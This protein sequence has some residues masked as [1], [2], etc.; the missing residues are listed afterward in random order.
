M[1]PCRAAFAKRIASLP[2]SDSFSIKLRAEDD[3]GG[4]PGNYQRA[5]S[6]AAGHE[7]QE[8]AHP[9][10]SEGETKTG[11]V[12]DPTEVFLCDDLESRRP[13]RGSVLLKRGQ[14][15]LIPA[16]I[17]TSQ[18]ASKYRET[19]VHID[20]NAHPSRSQQTVDVFSAVQF[21]PEAVAIPKGVDTYN[22]VEGADW[23][24]A[25]ADSAARSCT[26]CSLRATWKLSFRARFGGRKALASSPAA[27]T[28]RGEKSVPTRIR[29]GLS[30]P[31]K[32][33]R[34]V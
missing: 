23:I 5:H 30:F 24:V 7:I 21:L 22:E 33:K 28:Q 20:V 1:L 17:R 14:V 11:R 8:G 25:L 27:C 2:T 6:S 3:S 12:W 13:K 4:F 31:Q 15:A 10:T 26:S 16:L 9:P 18:S 32:A 29:L 34:G 19:V